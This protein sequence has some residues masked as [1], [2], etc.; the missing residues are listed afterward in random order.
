MVG[1]MSQPRIERCQIFL[2]QVNATILVGSERFIERMLGVLS[3]SV[4]EQRFSSGTDAPA[5]GPQEMGELAGGFEYP[6]VNAAIARFKK[7][8]KIDRELRSTPYS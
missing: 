3:G 8:L 2:W 5:Y 7:R 4:R 6:A 1:T